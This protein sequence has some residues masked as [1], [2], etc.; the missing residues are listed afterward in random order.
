MEH[1]RIN[2]YIG[3]DF[4]KVKIDPDELITEEGAKSWHVHFR[5]KTLGGNEFSI[6]TIIT[7]WSKYPSVLKDIINAVELHNHICPGLLAGY[8]IAKYLEK[9]YPLRNGETLVVWAIPPYCKD[10]V[11]Q[12]IF[13]ATVGKRRMAVMY[14]PQKDKLYPE[15]KDLAGIYVKMDKY[16]NAKAIVIGFNWNKLFEDCGISGKDFRNFTSYKWW[17]ARLRADVIMLNHNADRYVTTLKVIDLGNQ[18]S[19]KSLN[20]KWMSVGEN[21]LVKLGLMKKEEKKTPLPFFVTI[22]GLVVALII[23]RIL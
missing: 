11:F 10:D 15:Y 13:D 17:W 19:V 21:P 2:S 18:G 7:V 9:N 5:N 6:I 12:E 1:N 4:N 22:V 20:A 8:Y 16:G 14:L 3:C 23:R